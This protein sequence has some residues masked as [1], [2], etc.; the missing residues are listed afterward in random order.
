MS[1][2]FAFHCASLLL[3]NFP[4]IF[5]L[6]YLHRE[7]LFLFLISMPLESPLYSISLRSIHFLTQL[8]KQTGLWSFIPQSQRCSKYLFGFIVTKLIFVG[9]WDPKPSLK[10]L[11]SVAWN[12]LLLVNSKTSCAKGKYPTDAVG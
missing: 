7:Y 9:A 6:F 12:R 8:Q 2:L 1:Y 4:I 11:L 3:E 5:S 10:Y